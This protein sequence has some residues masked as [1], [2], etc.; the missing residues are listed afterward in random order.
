MSLQER[1]QYYVCVSVHS[2]LQLACV[3]SQGHKDLVKDC[4]QARLERHILMEE[5][6]R[7]H[8][9]DT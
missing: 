4:V 8:I 9:Q 3:V 7:P 1:H 6:Q 5:P 2:H